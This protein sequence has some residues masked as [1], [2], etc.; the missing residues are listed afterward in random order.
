MPMAETD[1]TS[2]ALDGEYQEEEPYFLLAKRDI[3]H[4]SEHVQSA[5]I[6][7]GAFPFGDGQLYIHL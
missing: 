5:L 7:W 3:W 6:Y 4:K 1:V 2:V